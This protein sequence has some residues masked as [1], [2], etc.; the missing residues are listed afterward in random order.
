[1]LSEQLWVQSLH[2]IVG[3]FWFGFYKIQQLFIPLLCMNL[4]NAREAAIQDTTVR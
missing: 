3:F 4:A 1:M 2:S